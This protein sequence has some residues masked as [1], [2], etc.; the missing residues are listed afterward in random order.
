L[1]EKGLF[2]LIALS[3]DTRQPLD[4]IP[5]V[6]VRVFQ[7]NRCGFICLFSEDHEHD[8]KLYGQ[9]VANMVDQELR[10]KPNA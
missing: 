8:W 6:P 4:D 1:D 10:N 9:G 2:G 3:S 5:A 7:C